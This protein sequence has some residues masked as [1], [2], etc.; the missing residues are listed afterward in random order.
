MNRN[1]FLFCALVTAVG[2]TKPTN[3]KVAPPQPPPVAAPLGV[4]VSAPRPAVVVPPA[5]VAPPVNV[6]VSLT[7]PPGW[8]STPS[9]RLPTGVVGG[10][11]NSALMSGVL[12]GVK[13]VR[14]SNKSAAE[15]VEETAVRLRADGVTVSPT[16]ASKDGR[17][18][19]IVMTT[20]DRAGMLTVRHCGAD[21]RVAVAFFG[22]WP[23]ENA[24]AAKLAYDG[25]VRSTVVE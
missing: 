18:A 9:D 12:V 4:F 16:H 8:E 21:G 7:S 3:V 15:D 17:T 13:G 6:H 24:A 22:I 14:P 20:D 19:W 23:K 2:C 11:F 25:V 10:F 5:A 1:V